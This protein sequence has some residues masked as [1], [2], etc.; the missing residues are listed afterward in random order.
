[1]TFKSADAFTTL[2]SASGVGATGHVELPKFDGLVQTTTDKVAAVGGEGNR[3]HAVLV[4]IGALQPFHKVAGSGIPNTHTLIERACGDVVT[5][6]GH[7]HGG[8]TVFD[9]QGVD[10]LAIQDIPKANSLVSTTG[11]NVPT[12]ASEVKRVDILLV[13]GKD[14]LDR[15]GIDV[16]NLTVRKEEKKG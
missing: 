1:M 15:P 14:M 13:T 16:P 8:H 5:I 11:C 3:V 9:A 10:Q 12:I 6:W 4:S 7:S 2:N